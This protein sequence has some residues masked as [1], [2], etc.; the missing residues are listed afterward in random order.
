MRTTA[1]VRVQLQ[2][3]QLSLGIDNGNLSES[4][5]ITGVVELSPAGLCEPQGEPAVRSTARAVVHV[6]QDSIRRNQLRGGRHGDLQD[7]VDR[8]ADLHRS[9][10]GLDQ[11]N[12][13]TGL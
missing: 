12:R 10:L 9:L 4:I 1:A 7:A 13:L 8:S 3:R 6:A 5:G 2:W 11:H